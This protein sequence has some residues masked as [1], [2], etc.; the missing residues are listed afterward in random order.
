MHSHSPLGKGDRAAATPTLPLSRKTLL[1]L[2][3]LLIVAVILSLRASTQ[4]LASHQGIL[5]ARSPNHRRRS[6]ASSS[7]SENDPRRAPLL[8]TESRR[9]A[10]AL[11]DLDKTLDRAIALDHRGDPLLGHSSQSS[12]DGPQEDERHRRPSQR[13][14]LLLALRKR[15]VKA[16]LVQYPLD[17]AATRNHP[18]AS[19][20]IFVGLVSYRSPLKCQRTV[21]SLFESAARPHRVYLGIVEAH[22]PTEESCIPQTMLDH[23]MLHEF[24]VSDHSKVRRLDPSHDAKGLIHGRYLAS[25]LYRGQDYVL[26]VTVGPAFG[27][28]WDVLLQQ[29][30]DFL[31]ERTGGS[32][33]IVLSSAHVQLGNESSQLVDSAK[34]RSFVEE[35]YNRTDSPI[36]GTTTKLCNVSFLEWDP[37]EAMRERGPWIEG[38]PI[39]QPQ[40]VSSPSAASDSADGGAKLL[41]TTW[42]PW[43]T[44]SFLFA[45]ASLLTN[46]PLDRRLLYLSHTQEVD[47]LLSASLWVANYTVFV[48]PPVAFVTDRPELEANLLFDLPLSQWQFH[49]LKA[50]QRVQFVLHSM[51]RHSNSNSNNK[52][53]MIADDAEDPTLAAGVN[54]VV[55]G[56]AA[57]GGG[58]GAAVPSFLEDIIPLYYA[59]GNFG[60]NDPSFSSDNQKKKRREGPSSWTEAYEWFRDQERSLESWYDAVGVY[61]LTQ[62]VKRSSWCPVP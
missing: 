27:W 16:P 42:Q 47:A 57:G 51:V 39:V 43:A 21:T 61:P 10:S 38:V 22:R 62:T 14:A 41:A 7:D 31:V 15:T 29:R 1:A 13:A 34:W 6:N 23:C 59:L 20:T 52:R 46:V 45:N 4:S 48:P 56:A 19:D 2:L 44:S 17:L 8:L 50:Q 24:C 60:S 40:V 49:K 55:G 28:R 33:R 30:Y 5:H 26:F 3:V 25:L 12:K 36:F 58:G 37:N 18:S 35:N 11:D 53:P 9:F 54:L 32:D